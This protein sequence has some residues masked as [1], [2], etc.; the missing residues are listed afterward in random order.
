MPDRSF[1]T[2]NLIV[3]LTD[4]LDYQLKLSATW[5]R[6]RCFAFKKKKE[7]GAILWAEKNRG[8]CN[9]SNVATLSSLSHYLDKLIFTPPQCKHT[10]L[11]WLYS[12][13]WHCWWINSNDEIHPIFS[14]RSEGFP[15]ESAPHQ[16]PTSEITKNFKLRLN[17]RV[18]KS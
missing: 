11:L 17:I 1:P 16:S 4:R 10:H 7:R 14:V 9:L 5:D 8:W 2:I 12:V 6:Y 18:Q 3:F 15:F 13:L